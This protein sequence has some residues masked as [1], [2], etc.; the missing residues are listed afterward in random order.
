MFLFFS[1]CKRRKQREKRRRQRPNSTRD[2]RTSA[3]RVE[4]QYDCHHGFR[5]NYR[6]DQHDMKILREIDRLLNSEDDFVEIDV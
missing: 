5:A 2:P 4:D 6:P 1:R 3:Y